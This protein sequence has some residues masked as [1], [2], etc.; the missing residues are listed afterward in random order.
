[1]STRRFSKYPSPRKLNIGVLGYLLIDIGVEAPLS[2]LCRQFLL[3]LASLA[4]EN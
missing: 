3:S 1:M 2:A 4:L